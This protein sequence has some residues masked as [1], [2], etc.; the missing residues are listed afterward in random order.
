MNEAFPSFVLDACALIAYLNGEEGSERVEARLLEAVGGAAEVHMSVVNVCEVYYDCIR[1]KGE[2]EAGRLLAEIQTLPI[3][4]VRTIDNPLLEMAG[5]LKVVEHV[6]LGDAFALAVA[7]VFGARLISC[8][9]HE[10]DPVADK[11]EI[12]FDWIR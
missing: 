12:E 5:R 11:G 2:A 9:H 6:S 8:D 1:V 4:I 7:K 10:F 3:S